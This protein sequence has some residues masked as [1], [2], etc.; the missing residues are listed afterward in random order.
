MEEIPRM[1]TTEMIHGGVPDGVAVSAIASLGTGLGA[2]PVLFTSHL[3]DRLR[4][5]FLSIG[6]GV[7]VSAAAFALLLPA[8]RLSQQS[9]H[10][11]SQLELVAIALGLGGALL[12]ALEAV[13]PQP[14]ITEQSEHDADRTHGRQIWLFVLAIALHHFPE[15]LAVGLSTAST[16]DMGVAIGVGLQNIPEGLMLALALRELGYGASFSLAMAT[17]SGWLEPLG[18]ALGIVIAGL[19]TAIAPVGMAMAAGAM[20]FVVFHELLPE[21]SLKRMNSSGSVGLVTGLLVMSVVEQ[22]AG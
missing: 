20:L 22:I 8:L 18:S 15:G 3:S 21:L 1:F 10:P 9:A 5:L 16:Q 7:M 6:G 17:I 11:G 4:T 13:L 14:T 12:Y 2:I 19:S